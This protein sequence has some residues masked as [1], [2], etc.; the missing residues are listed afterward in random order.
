MDTFT[1]RKCKEPKP[2]SDFQPCEF[3]SKRM[4]CRC[5]KREHS[6]LWMRANP[7]PCPRKP[8]EGEL[9]PGS[10]GSLA[11]LVVCADL[12]DKGFAVFRSVSPNCFCDLIAIKGSEERRIEVR[13]GAYTPNGLVTFVRSHDPRAT[14]FAVYVHADRSIHYLG[15]DEL[16]S[17]CRLAQ[18]GPAA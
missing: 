17:Q 7:Q 18:N 9:S 2:Q 13:T 16:P 11:E 6:R 14:E 12:L 5:C 15:V 8:Y 1:C 4:W 3:K 10:K